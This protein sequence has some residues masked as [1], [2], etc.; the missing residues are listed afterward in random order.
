MRININADHEPAAP[1]TKDQKIE[2]IFMVRK[3]I[4]AYNVRHLRYS[5]RMSRDDVAA[6]CGLSAHSIVQAERE[7]VDVKLTTLIRIAKGFNITLD[8]LIGGRI[9]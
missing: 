5:Y 4:I 8:Q 1:A 9:K 2:K 7:D 3:G 6:R